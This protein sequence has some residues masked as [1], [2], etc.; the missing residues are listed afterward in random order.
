MWYNKS[1]LNYI[2]RCNAIG[3]VLTERMCNDEGSIFWEGRKNEYHG[4]LPVRSRVGW[5]RY[6]CE[7]YWFQRWC[8]S[9]NIH[10]DSCRT[11]CNLRF[12][13]GAGKL[14]VSRLFELYLLIINSAF[15]SLLCF[16]FYFWIIDF[17]TSSYF[18]HFFK[19]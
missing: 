6:A 15:N 1:G 17:F 7:A 9:P 18:I 11:C 13:W 3:K 8:C 5:R 16:I 12:T 4:A 10:G 19:C 14:T 2:I